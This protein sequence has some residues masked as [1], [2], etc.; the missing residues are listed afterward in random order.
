MVANMIMEGVYMYQSN[1]TQNYCIT[2][3]TQYCI[4][5][6]NDISVARPETTRSC[7]VASTF[8]ALPSPVKQDSHNSITR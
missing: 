1:H 3:F 5:V 6:V 8:Q 2:T 7:T 4:Y